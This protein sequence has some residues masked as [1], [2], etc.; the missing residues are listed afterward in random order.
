MDQKIYV[1]LLVY[2]GWK[3]TLECLESVLKS[4]HKNYQIVVVDNNS[5]NNS[6]DHIAAW[7]EGKEIANVD[8]PMLAE[9]STPHSKK[10]LN[11]ILYNKFQATQGGVREKEDKLVNPIVLIQ[12]GENKGF[13]AGNNIGIKYILS[14]NDAHHVW[15]LN[16]DTVIEP[17]TLTNLTDTA[18]QYISKGEKVGIIGN[19]LM[20]Y[21]APTIIQS[22]GGV[23][24]KWLATTKH[25]G[26]FEA[27]AGQYNNGS[28]S[29]N[30]DYPIGASLFVS[31]AFIRDVGLL[32]EDYFLYFEE[33]DW[34]IRGKEKGWRLGYCW[35]ANV[36]HKEGGSIGS[37]S[38]AKQK[39][40][41]ADYYG[42][43]NRIVFTKKF[44]KSK[45]W[46]VKFGFIF[47]VFNR[48]KRGQS[49]RLGLIVKAMM[50]S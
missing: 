9:L 35:K 19:K 36:F 4:D 47:V 1:L 38:H 32:C 7:A 11:Y 10:P 46:S 21:N 33:L 28:V 15:L 48:I 2:N 50:N 20:H 30:I 14:K 39:S 26:A 12:S 18:S 17:R 49:S 25:V 27:D 29:E 43:R 22:V 16:N 34:T 23:Y 6:L 24:N 45:I 5:P 3:D 13:A 40:E 44:Y 8:N 31:V 42:S 37:S 41:L